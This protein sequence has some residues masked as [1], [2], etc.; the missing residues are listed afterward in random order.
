MDDEEGRCLLDVIWLPPPGPQYLKLSS[1]LCSSDPQALND[2]LHGSDQLAPAGEGI[3][4]EVPSSA[5]SVDISFLGEDLLGSPASYGTE[6]PCD[7][8]QQSLQEA[9]ITPQT[10]QGGDDLAA[11]GVHVQASPK[12]QPASLPTQDSPQALD[13]DLSSL[14][15]AVIAQQPLL[16]HPVTAQFV[17]KTVNVQ[18]LVHQVRLSSVAV[19]PIAGIQTMSN[20][21]TKV[22]R[23]QTVDWQCGQTTVLPDDQPSRTGLLAKPGLTSPMAAPLSEHPVTATLGI[24]APFQ[25]NIT[26]NCLNGESL[27]AHM[28]SAQAAVGHTTGNQL[29]Q[30]PV[31]T[32]VIQRSSTPIQPKH[33]VNIQPKLVQL[34]PKSSFPPNSPHV[35]TA[36]KTSIEAAQQQQKAWQ[37][38]A[39]TARTSGPGVLLSTQA[40]AVSQTI[41]TNRVKQPSQQGQPKSSKPVSVRVLQQGTGVVLQ[42]QSLPRALLTGQGQSTLPGHLATRVS[43]STGPQRLSAIQSGPVLTTQSGSVLA[44]HRQPATGRIVGRVQASPGQIVCSQP[45]PAHVLMTQ[46]VVGQSITSHCD[47]GQVY[48]A[49]NSQLTVN[50]GAAQRLSISVQ[51][52]PSQ[53]TLSTSFLVPSQLEASFGSQLDLSGQTPEGQLDPTVPLPNQLPVLNETE[54]GPALSIQQSSTS[55]PDS[56]IVKIPFAPQSPFTSA[57]ELQQIPALAQCRQQMHQSQ[58]QPAE[59]HHSGLLSALASKPSSISAKTT[60]NNQGA[61][62][63]A[64][65]ADQLLLFQQKEQKQQL[66][67]Q[68]ALKLQQ[69]KGLSLTS[70]NGLAVPLSAS[71]VPPSGSRP[72]VQTN[73]VLIPANTFLVEPKNQTVLPQSQPSQFLPALSGQTTSS[74]ISN[75]TGLN[76]TLSKGSIQIQMIGKGIAHITSTANQHLQSALFEGSVGKLKKTAAATLTR[77]DL[78]LEKFYKDQTSVLQPDCNTPFNSFEDTVFRLLPYHVCKGTLPTNVDFNKVDEEFEVISTQLLKRTQV[79]LNKYRLLL[80]EESRRTNPS[81]E[82]VMIDRMF[83]QEEKV[84]FLEAKRLAKNN[85]DAY[86]TSVFKPRIANTLPITS[87]PILGSDQEVQCSPQAQLK[88]YVASSRGGLKLK[89]RQEVVHNSE[90]EQLWPAGTQ[91][92]PAPTGPFSLTA[93]TLRQT[94]GEPGCRFTAPAEKWQL[95][96]G[97]TQESGGCLTDLRKSRRNLPCDSTPG[98]G[99]DQ[100]KTSPLSTKLH[101]SLEHNVN[102]QATTIEPGPGHCPVQ[103]SHD[104]HVQNRLHLHVDRQGPGRTGVDINN[105][106]KAGFVGDLPLPQPKRRKCDSVDNANSMGHSP[107]DTALSA[108]LQSAINSLLD[109]QRHQSSEPRT[110]IPQKDDRNLPP[111]SPPASSADFLQSDPDS[112]LAEVTTSTLEE[113]V[114]S[115][116]GD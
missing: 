2:F 41:A 84:A 18:H 54:L 110:P 77:G 115:I 57:L 55:D 67:Y 83:I 93:N 11:G 95:G 100:S 28:G 82:M 72:G 78:L 4:H 21:T 6:Q 43:A 19:Q 113:A 88:T 36:S 38:L 74:M 46:N 51:P 7:I 37:N 109:L 5:S 87:G 94:D 1:V 45:M 73:T 106:V 26:S 17:N 81:S 63:A 13:T 103:S 39:V 30:V 92:R 3:S 64:L 96:P 66:L 42:S 112:G 12:P 76:V 60:D 47:L 97:E 85:P 15:P 75:L 35:Q 98:L 23:T 52:Q 104:S 91:A 33:L 114:N 69:E 108:H 53:P 61:T 10:L 62:G 32:R 9:N 8:L 25:K 89:I 71:S 44:I 90:L 24:S 86:I 99:P 105:H 50:E 111:Y 16:Q 68:Q 56:N 65:N 80:F 31:L 27:F 59:H 48:T 22:G 40:P 79:M 102:Q 116:L 101:R 29:V 107:Q 34:S 20:G 70:G 14:A 49:S 58:S